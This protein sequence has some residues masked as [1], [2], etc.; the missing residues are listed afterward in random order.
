M[1]YISADENS[2][3]FK[4][5]YVFFEIRLEANKKKHLPFLAYT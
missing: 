3:M 2:L 1:K 4:I 5:N